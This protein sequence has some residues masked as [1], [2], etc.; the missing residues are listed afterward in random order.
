MLSSRR[1]RHLSVATAVL[2]VAVLTACA[3]EGEPPAPEPTTADE[4][5]TRPDEF[6][7]VGTWLFD[8]EHMVPMV[9]AESG[10]ALD[11]FTGRITF[12]AGDDGFAHV[13]YVDATQT[14]QMDDGS[15]VLVRNG[16]DSASYFLDD[17]G[18]FYTIDVIVD[19]QITGTAVS[20]GVSVPIDPSMVQDA[21]SLMSQ[22]TFRCVGETLTMESRGATATLARIS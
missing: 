19:S 16:R 1:L 7:I 17:D 20:E 10:V 15:V 8:N 3:S 14:A 18:S 5:A 2:L 22:T 12:T 4:V 11:S 9:A 21:H 13:D 6:C